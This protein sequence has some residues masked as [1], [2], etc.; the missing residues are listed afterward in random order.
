MFV[1]KQSFFVLT[2]GNYTRFPFLMKITIALNFKNGGD[3][4]MDLENLK[5]QFPCLQLRKN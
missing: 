1:D 5:K 4:K 2:Q 3:E